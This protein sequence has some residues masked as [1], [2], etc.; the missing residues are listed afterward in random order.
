MCY[1]LLNLVLFVQFKKHEATLLKVKPLV[2][3]IPDLDPDMLLINK[4]YI[5]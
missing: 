4:R 3:L 5:Q 2:D 1:A